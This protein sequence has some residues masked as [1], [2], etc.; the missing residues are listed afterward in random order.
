MCSSAILDG[1]TVIEQAK[2]GLITVF[3][4]IRNV[5]DSEQIN[6]DEF[7]SAMVKLVNQ[8]ITLYLDHSVKPLSLLDYQPIVHRYYYMGW[9]QTKQGK[10]SEAWAIHE[11]T[12]RISRECLPPNHPRFGIAYSYISLLY[13]TMND[14]SRALVCG[15]A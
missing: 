14:H 13:L 15:C 5:L 10:L 2:D 4:T 6:E 9:V 1:N 7:H 8:L 12:L 3:S 11:H